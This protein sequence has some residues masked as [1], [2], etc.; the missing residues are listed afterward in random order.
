MSINI[1]QYKTSDL[2]IVSVQAGE[3][4]ETK[5]ASTPQ[6]DP[7]MPDPCQSDPALP[8]LDVGMLDENVEECVPAKKLKTAEDSD[9][10]PRFPKLEQA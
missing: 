5:I 2:L 1:I 9:D 8:G 3:I 6:T 4:S 7:C 10:Q